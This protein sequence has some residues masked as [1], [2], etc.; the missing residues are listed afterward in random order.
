MHYASCSSTYKYI[1]ELLSS[2]NTQHFFLSFLYLDNELHRSLRGSTCCCQA[3]PFIFISSLSLQHRW[4]EGVHVLRTGTS[5]HSPSLLAPIT[6][7]FSLSLS[8]F[9]DSVCVLWWWKMGTYGARRITYYS[10]VKNTNKGTTFGA[11]RTYHW[12]LV[13]SKVLY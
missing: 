3:A 11:S 5:L 1:V 13:H 12:D 9:L 6:S 8:L 2:L 4:L 10:V 7:F